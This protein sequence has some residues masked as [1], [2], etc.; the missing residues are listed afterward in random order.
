MAV[1]SASIQQALRRSRMFSDCDDAVLAR[2][3]AATVH[4]RI[5]R[6]D[7]V[8]RA[9][10]PAVF[11][12]TISAGLVKIVRRSA[13]ESDSIVALFGPR[14]TIGNLAVAAHGTYPADAIAAT[15]EAGFLCVG[16]EEI[17]DLTMRSSCVARAM[18]RSLVEH[19]Q[20][21]HAKIAIMSAGSVE[22]RL[23]ALFF[24]LMDRFGDEDGEGSHFIPVALSRGDPA[25]LVGATIETAVRTMSRWQ[26]SGVIETTKDGFR[27]PDPGRLRSAV[28]FPGT[29]ACPAA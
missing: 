27:I 21:L 20:A 11:L 3:A 8:F 17:R 18:S 9:G 23:A 2:L 19:S 13:G 29:W 1:S 16:A 14:E 25:C 24:H 15:D 6:G 5:A 10:Y 12:A 7:A 22:R 4:R 26:K 28:D